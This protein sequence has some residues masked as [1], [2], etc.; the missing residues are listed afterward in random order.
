MAFLL[1][2]IPMTL[3]L[4]PI[5]LENRGPE[6]LILDWTFYYKNLSFADTLGTSELCAWRSRRPS[7]RLTTDRSLLS[8]VDA[9]LFFGYRL[10]TSQLPSS[11]R[12]P[13]QTYVY[14]NKESPTRSVSSPLSLLHSLILPPFNWKERMVALRLSSLKDVPPNYFNWT[15]TYRS[16]SDIVDRYGEFRPISRAEGEAAFREAETAVKQK[17]R[18]LAWVVSNCQRDRGLVPSERGAYIRALQRETSL[19]QYGHCNHRPCPS[20]C[21]E[22]DADCQQDCDAHIKANFRFY[23]SMENTVCDEYVTEKFFVRALANYAVPVVLSRATHPLPIPQDSFIA[24]D[25]FPSPAHLAA[26]LHRLS[27]SPTQLLAFQAW[28]R[29][30]RVRI[31]WFKE[32]LCQ[33]CQALHEEREPRVVQDIH[34]WFQEQATCRDAYGLQ[35]L[36]LSSSGTT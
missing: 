17:S 35:L 14:L 7:C 3:I 23:L 8:S 1:A 5:L 6:K 32:T 25:D 12:S 31:V 4:T 36:N 20:Y 21:A 2:L 22:G 24:A 16:D 33:L 10:R 9:I 30:F 29:H 11:H 19:E 27:N 15:L 28:R 26:E 13:R 18:G 34:G